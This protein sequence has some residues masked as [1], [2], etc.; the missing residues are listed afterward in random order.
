M[1]VRMYVL[2]MFACMHVC[3]RV[4]MYLYCVYALRVCV[5]VRARVCMCGC[6]SYACMH[7][8][9]YECIHIFMYECIHILYVCMYLCGCITCE[10]QRKQE[11]EVEEQVGTSLRQCMLSFSRSYSHC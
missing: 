2:C 10:Q 8:C 6:V 4:C 1:Y 7:A 9:M 11:S 5:C 3:M